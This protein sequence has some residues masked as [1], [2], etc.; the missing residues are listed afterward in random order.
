MRDRSIRLAVFIC[1]CLAAFAV[2][3]ESGLPPRGDSILDREFDLAGK[4]SQETQY[5]LMESRLITYALDGKRVG[6]RYF[7]SV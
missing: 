1:A 7:G 6:I 4:R 5:Y 2:Q 3:V